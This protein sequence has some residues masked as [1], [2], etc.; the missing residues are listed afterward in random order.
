MRKIY[1][2]ILI[3]GLASNACLPAFLQPA[4]SPT[5]DID[6]QATI[7]AGLTFA[8][9][10]LE[11]E[12]TPSLAPS[13]TRTRTATVTASVTNTVT[14]STPATQS[15]TPF[16]TITTGTASTPTNVTGTPGTP[17]LGTATNSSPTSTLFPR[18]Y[19]TQPPAIPFGRLKLI[20]RSKAE[21]YISI[22]CVTA[23][24]QVSII[25]YPVP[26]R[27]EVR[28]P[29]GKCIYVAWVGGRKMS[30]SFSLGKS[31][32]KTITLYKDRIGIK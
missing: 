7:A 12:A 25:E 29:A 23:D 30:G 20:N 9:Q 27:L 10:S 3:A 18:F 11:P 13:A 28:A 24:G 2:V 6:V 21:A 31:S 4:V 16:A 19:G 14:S 17:G 1:F 32:E 22:Q 5:E 26:R 8:S 15:E